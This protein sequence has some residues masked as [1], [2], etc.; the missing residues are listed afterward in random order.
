MTADLIN[1]RRAR[2]SKARD[3]AEKLAEQN[4]AKFGRSKSEKIISSSNLALE[5]KKLESHKRDE[6]WPKT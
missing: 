5:T 1:L 3:E 6:P 2:K 4:R